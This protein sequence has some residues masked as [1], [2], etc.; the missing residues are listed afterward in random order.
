MLFYATDFA[1]NLA[2]FLHV[3]CGVFRFNENDFFYCRMPKRA[4][5]KN[6]AVEPSP[7]LNKT[8][9]DW[10]VLNVSY[11]ASKFHIG[12]TEKIGHNIWDIYGSTKP[13]FIFCIEFYKNYMK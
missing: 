5:E 2:N 7:K 10:K 12:R 8:N 1:Q 3:S 11:I 6:A 13:N 9:T 4:A